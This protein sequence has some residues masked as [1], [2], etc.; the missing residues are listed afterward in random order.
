VTHPSPALGIVCCACRPAAVHHIHELALLAGAMTPA[1]HARTAHAPQVYQQEYTQLMKQVSEAVEE[2]RRG[3]EQGWQQLGIGP[4]ARERSDFERKFLSYVPPAPPF[5]LPRT[6][7]LA[8]GEGARP[9]RRC[10]RAPACTAEDTRTCRHCMRDMRCMSG[11][12]WTQVVGAGARAGRAQPGPVRT[13]ARR[14]PR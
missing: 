12:G 10:M 6:V 3:I 5:P 1:Q 7:S 4:E 14:A 8:H 13:P 11:S 9:E 2:A